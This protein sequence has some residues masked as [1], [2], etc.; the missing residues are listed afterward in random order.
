MFGLTV[1][2]RAQLDQAFDR[3]HVLRAQHSAA[4]VHG[5][6]DVLVEDDLGDAV[7]V[8]QMNEDHAAQVAAA[9]HPAHQHDAFGRRRRRAAPRRCA[10]GA[11]R[12]ENPVDTRFPYRC[13]QFGRSS[14][15]RSRPGQLRCSPVA[16]FFQRICARRRF[17]CRRRSACSAR[18]ACWPVPW[19]ASACLRPTFH[20]DAV[21]R[22][23]RAPA[24][25]ACAQRR[26]AQRRD[27]Q[28]ERRLAVWSP[29]TLIT[30]RSS[31]IEKPMPGAVH[32]RAERFR[33]P[34]VAAA[35]Q[36]RILRAQARR[37]PLRT[38]CACSNRGRAPGAGGPRKR[39]RGRPDTAA[40]PRSAAR[41]ASHR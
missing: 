30:R 40:P 19:P 25:A 14:S 3:D 18:R 7:A 29:S 37:A 24:R 35:A 8:A 12:P 32:L 31:P 22:A 11:G 20:R 4:A 1:S 13:C 26:F 27:E 38:W 28:I 36:H 10:C 2:R 39:S 17:R 34:V 21:A 41:H 33:Q 23:V 5:R 16:M 15:R 9:V 6:V